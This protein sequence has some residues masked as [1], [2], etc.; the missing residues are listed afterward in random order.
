M[1]TTHI[2]LDMF[3]SLGVFS[4]G[5]T[6]CKFIT[7]ERWILAFMFTIFSICAAMPLIK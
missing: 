7:E 4:G 5:F 1:D 3:F 2:I 6:V